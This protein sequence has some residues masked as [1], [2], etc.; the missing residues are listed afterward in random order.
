M[1]DAA[2]T[3]TLG[4]LASQDNLDALDFTTR[5]VAA[6]WRDGRPIGCAWIATGTFEERELGLRFELTPADA[7]LF[8]AAV[9]PQFRDRAV[10]RRVLEFLIDELRRA[11]AKRLLFGVT[12][13]NEPSRRAHA[14]QGAVQ[15]GRI[16]ALRLLGR[17]FCRCSGRVR[18]APGRAV[19]PGVVTLAVDP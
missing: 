11:G 1:T 17:P 13:G 3:A 16:V 4:P 9:A 19:A 10:Y 14:R 8:A 12:A 18:R 5:R 2:E 15:V 6:A 7:W